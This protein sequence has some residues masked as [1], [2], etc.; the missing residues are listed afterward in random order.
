[1]DHLFLCSPWLLHGISQTEHE[2]AATIKFAEIAADQVDG[3]D[4]IMGIEVTE[5]VFASAEARNALVNELVEG[6]ELPVYLR[7]RITAP[8][9]YMQYRDSDALTGLSEVVAA[10]DANERSV[11]L[12]QSGLCGWLM[13]AFG[14]RSFGAGFAASLQRNIP[15]A[16]G[17]GGFPPLHWYFVPEL[18]SF[19]LAEELEDVADIDGFSTCEC[20]YCD[21]ELPAEGAAF[22]ATA[23]GKHFVW[24]CSKLANKLT[25][26]TPHRV[27]RSD[28]TRLSR[29]QTRLRIASNLRIGRSLH[30]LDSW[31]SLVS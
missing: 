28:W 13:T 26:M 5:G 3:E 31:S 7:M 10:L 6:P 18:L 16:S 30:T 14:A 25:R 4:L 2:L 9:G 15:P 24:W 29:S 20:P 27:C 19:V 11:A 12:P 1:M 8:P 22:D 21:G 23:A 17:G